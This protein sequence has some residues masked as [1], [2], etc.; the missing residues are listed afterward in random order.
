VVLFRGRGEDV[1]VF[2]LLRGAK[3]SF[4]GDFYAFPGGRLDEEDKAIPVEGAEGEEAAHRVAAARELFEET[5]VLLA[6][7]TASQAELDGARREVLEGKLKFAEVLRRFGLTLRASD[8]LPAGRYVTPATMPIR[9]DCR[10]FLAEAPPEAQARVWPGE[11]ADGGWVRPAAALER[12]GDGTALL[13][14]PNL[15]AL[16]VLA[17]FTE[18]GEVQARLAHPPHMVGFIP[19]RIQFQ[20]GIRFFSLRSPTLVPAT[21]TNAYLLGNRELLIVDPGAVDDAE[22]SKLLGLLRELM[23][24]GMKPLAV[25]LTH[26]HQ[27]HIGGVALLK[28]GLGLPLWCHALTADR[29]AIPADRL[30]NDGELLT[31]DGDPIMRWRVLHTPGHARGHVSLVEERTR[32]AVVGDMVAGLGTILIDPPEGDMAEYVRQL[33]RLRDLPVRALY[34]AHGSPLPDGP[35]KLD[36]YLQHRKAREERVLAALG[37]APRRLEEV[38]G[39]AYGDT[40]LVPAIITERSTLAILLKLVAEGYAKEDGGGFLL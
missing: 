15:Y 8:F 10:F 17:G 28:R 39:E 18:S 4:A 38:A 22:A 34:P 1:E 3:V 32:A 14:P 9:F 29:L 11:A 35:G 27:D 20:Q 26:H 31:V 37:A 13:H 30:L 40:P 7:G 19:S 6:S 12:W 23:A 25:V 16:E 2:W 21:H 24:E 5:G 36:E 33:A